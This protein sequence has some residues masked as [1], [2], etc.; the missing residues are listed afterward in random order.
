MRYLI[1]PKDRKYVER[2][3]FLSSAKRF[4]DK[5]GK[6]LQDTIAKIG[7]DNAK[8]AS[9]RVVQKQQKLREI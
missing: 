1:K 9:K 5:Y 4:G 6:K 8:T 2:Y 7:I 3:G